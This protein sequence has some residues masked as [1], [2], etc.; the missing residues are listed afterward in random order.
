MVK[1]ND[2]QKG[3]VATGAAAVVGAA[4][5]VAGASFIPTDANAAESENPQDDDAQ[6]VAA[7]PQ[8]GAHAEHANTTHASG[9]HTASASHSHAAD[10]SQQE[11]HA[12]AVDHVSNGPGDHA[13]SAT[14]GIGG[15][16]PAS[17]D[18]PQ[19]APAP[20]NGGDPEV[21]VL[22]SEV[23]TAD[24]GS[25]AEIAAVSVNGQSVVFADTTMDGYANIA[26]TD[27]NGNGQIDDNEIVD[28]SDQ[29]IS[30]QPF[31]GGAGM[32]DTASSDAN[33]PA[34]PDNT[35]ASTDEPDYTNDANVD[36][37]M[38]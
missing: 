13:H 36:D 9:A 19:P 22:G 25:Q 15:N 10:V 26:A 35:L 24:D 32:V 29:G 28:V 31:R 4:A 23:V 20:A 16:T 34:Q 12:E 2:K 37:F 17:H 33:T 14:N 7:E 6:V 3:R 5:G 8:Q 30:M 21:V 27:V 11:H 38:A 18:D 1:M